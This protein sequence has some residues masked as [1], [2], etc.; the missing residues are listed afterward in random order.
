MGGSTR[1]SSLQLCVG[2]FSTIARL[3]R[4][5]KEKE[6]ARSLQKLDPVYIAQ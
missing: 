1:I 3:A 2:L 6:T 4:F 5:N